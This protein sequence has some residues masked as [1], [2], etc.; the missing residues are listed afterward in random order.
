MNNNIINELKKNHKKGLSKIFIE[1]TGVGRAKVLLHILNIC[2]LAEEKKIITAT[3][4][5]YTQNG[6]N[7]NDIEYYYLIK[8]ATTRGLL[9][10]EKISSKNLFTRMDQIDRIL[11]SENSRDLDNI[12]VEIVQDIF[13]QLVFQNKLKRSIEILEYLVIKEEYP[14]INSI[15][16]LTEKLVNQNA[17]SIAKNI[18]DSLG[19]KFDNS[20]VFLATKGNIYSSMKYYEDSIYL[21]TRAKN[22]QPT[23]ELIDISIGDSQKHLHNYNEALKHYSVKI[24]TESDKIL[25]VKD[26]KKLLLSFRPFYESVIEK[27]DCIENFF[28]SKNLITINPNE[29]IYGDLFYAAYHDLNFKEIKHQFDSKIKVKAQSQQPA[30]SP[31][32]NN[33]ILIINDFKPGSSVDLPLIKGLLSNLKS[34][35]ITILNIGSPVP[36]TATQLPIINVNLSDSIQ[37]ILKIEPAI[38]VY[39]AIG[40]NDAT[41][42]LANLRFAK[43]QIAA[44]G[45]PV[46]SGLSTIDYFISAKWFE[47]DNCDEH[48]TEHIVLLGG[49]GTNMSPPKLEPLFEP[50]L[51]YSPAPTEKLFLCPG[52][53]YKYQPEFDEFIFKLLDL[54]T[55]IIVC[56]FQ[57]NQYSNSYLSSGE[58]LLKRLHSYFLKHKRPEYCSRLRLLSFMSNSAF[59]WQLC[60]SFCVIDSYPFSG[61]NTIISALTCRTPTITIE[62]KYMRGRFGSGILKNIGLDDFVAT[63]MSGAI[64]IC[65]NLLSNSNLTI[66]FK[67]TLNTNFDSIFSNSSSK[68][69]DIFLNGI[70]N[71]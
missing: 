15:C 66:K 54:D 23:N 42:R 17:T 55:S 1:N 63:S 32:K 39:P 38:I 36:Q 59:Q 6:Y 18:L 51:N 69:L 12:A 7:I 48:Y 2:I 43:Y 56:F 50:L 4:N 9:E 26:Q 20:F 3:I 19:E 11:N 70:L 22:I 64:E 37:L 62:G 16:T 40:M 44:W 14:S 68:D 47:P 60:N 8:Q 52:A 24:P 34:N 71:K 35:D 27:S 21:Y 53:P 5:Y 30:I 58:L 10:K 33:K 25:N 31:N 65:K 13:T 67:S 49:T 28:S 45:H 41:Y 61:Y 57:D 46:T 29:A